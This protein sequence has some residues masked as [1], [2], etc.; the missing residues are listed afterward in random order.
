[1]KISQRTRIKL[2]VS[3]RR[4]VECTSSNRKF[5]NEINHSHFKFYIQNNV[6]WNISHWTVIMSSSYKQQDGPLHELSLEILHLFTRWYQ[7][8]MWLFFAKF[9]VAFVNQICYFLIKKL[10]NFP[11]TRLEVVCSRAITLEHFFWLD[12][13]GLK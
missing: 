9:N 13:L 5:K 6:N 2:I 12:M 7:R 8:V 1:M 4:H 11:Y 3:I 10:H